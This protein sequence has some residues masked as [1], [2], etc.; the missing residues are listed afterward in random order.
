MIGAEGD[1]WVGS[2][3]EVGEHLR[4]R[5]GRRLRLLRGGWDVLWC[6]LYSSSDPESEAER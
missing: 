2:R 3:M 5:C 4:G 1:D 6:G